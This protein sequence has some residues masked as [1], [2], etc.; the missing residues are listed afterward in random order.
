MSLLGIKECEARVEMYTERAKNALDS[1]D[2]AGD[3][4]FLKNLADALAER[5]Y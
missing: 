1:G 4:E 5:K 3:T 2:W